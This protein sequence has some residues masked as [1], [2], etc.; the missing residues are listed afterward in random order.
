MCS[1]TLFVIEMTYATSLLDLDSYLKYLVISILLK[2]WS[3]NKNVY[4]YE[5]YYYIL[6]LLLSLLFSEL[7]L[8]KVMI[9]HGGITPSCPFPA[10]MTPFSGRAFINEEAT[11]CIN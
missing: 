6:F 7:S 2:G 1:L 3:E 9:K 8:L 11:D 10:L 5:L 4:P